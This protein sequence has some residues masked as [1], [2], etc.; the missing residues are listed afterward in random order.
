M[1]RKFGAIAFAGLCG[2]ASFVLVAMSGAPAQAQSLPPG[3]CVPVV[4]S[5][6]N[7]ISSGSTSISFPIPNNLSGAFNVCPNPNN[8][9][10][11]NG[12]GIPGGSCTIPNPTFS[13]PTITNQSQ[14]LAASAFCFSTSTS[15]LQQAASA[16]INAAQVG[17]NVVQIQNQQIKDLIRDRQSG[18]AANA[19]VYVPAFAGV[20]ENASGAATELPW[21]MSAYTKRDPQRSILKAPPKAVAGPSVQ[22]ATWA[23]G[24][25]DHET[26]DEV[27]GGIDFGRRTNTAG[28]IGGAYAILSNFNLPFS[29][30]G[31]VLVLGAFGGETTSHVRNNNGT[32][33]RVTGP[34]V[35]GNAIWMRGAFSADS[36]VKADFFDVAPSTLITELHL[37]TVNSTTNASYR[38]DV[39]NWWMEPTAGVGFTWTQW[40]TA[41]RAM[42]FVDGHQTRLTAGS[43]FGTSWNW[44]NVK[45][46]PVLGLFVYDDV[47]I[48]GGTLAAAVGVPLVPTD[49]GK[50]FGQAT[51]KL[52]FDWGRGLST[53][54][55]GEA[56]GR[57]GVFGAA[58]R[59]GVTYVWNNT[60]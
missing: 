35:G 36:T 56:R 2:I 25:F 18:R 47:D 53:F 45:V 27:Q 28:G 26:R 21:N 46:E 8:T 19:S 52:S 60:P 1:L 32:T 33:A 58:G 17:L 12:P 23:V 55:E 54:I 11:V 6:G 4:F 31:D 49:E 5:N 57:N 3:T 48:S 51:G 13:G 22:Y 41:S 29:M 40:D 16:A 24:F 43:R 44:N 14:I 9:V 15:N 50:L 38:I 20:P 59:L 30:P 42:G 34:G 10:T 37:T 7:T 39:T